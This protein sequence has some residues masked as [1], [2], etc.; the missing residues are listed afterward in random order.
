MSKVVSIPGNL[1]LLRIYDKVR[2]AGNFTS[3]G[4]RFFRGKLYLKNAVEIPA[5]D[6]NAVEFICATGGRKPMTTMFINKSVESTGLG[7]HKV[8][9]C[10]LG[11]MHDM[12][13]VKVAKPEHVVGH[14]VVCMSTDSQE[15]SENIRT[16][17]NTKFVRYFVRET[18]TNT[19]NSKHLFEYV[20]DVDLSRPWADEDLYEFYKLD[21]EEISE[22]EN[23][24]KERT[25]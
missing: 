15:E 19:A 23:S 17:L 13:V 6:D 18:R 3:I 9:M 5:E 1:N 7:K 8:V 11:N 12:G 2:A 10:Q 21:D 20:P 22:I 14:S 16:Y 24:T 4:G 25:T